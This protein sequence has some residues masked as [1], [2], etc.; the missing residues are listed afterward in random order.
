MEHVTIY[1]RSSCG[2]CVRAKRLCEA[3]GIPFT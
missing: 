2:F 1:G 3:K